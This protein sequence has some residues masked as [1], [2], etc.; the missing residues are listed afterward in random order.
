MDKVIEIMFNKVTPYRVFWYA[1]ITKVFIY[2]HL[3]L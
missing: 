3:Y 1:V 2:G